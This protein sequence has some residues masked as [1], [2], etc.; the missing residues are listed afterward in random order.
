[1]NDCGL[2]IPPERSKSKSIGVG[3]AMHYRYAFPRRSKSILEIDVNQYHL[4]TELLLVDV[5]VTE[6]QITDCYL[7]TN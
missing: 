5:K 7:L 1:M 2:I 6:K 3:W 4:Q